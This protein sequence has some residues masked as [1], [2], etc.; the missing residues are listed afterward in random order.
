MKKNKTVKIGC[1]GVD[2]GLVLICDPCYIYSNDKEGG[3]SEDFPK[4]WEEFLEKFVEDRDSNALSFKA[5]H[6]G[7]GVL[8]STGYGDGYYPVYA[9]YDEDGVIERLVIDFNSWCE[10]E[11]K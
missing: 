4:T 7:L 9:E 1:F 8:S 3:L 11:D 5:G 10:E 6:L 2:A